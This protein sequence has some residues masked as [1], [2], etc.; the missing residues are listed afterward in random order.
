M[1][2]PRVCVSGSVWTGTVRA[3]WYGRFVAEVLMGLASY[4]RHSF[5]GQ[6]P[7]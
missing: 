1:E 6:T 7:Q 4:D 3:K 5:L 2:G